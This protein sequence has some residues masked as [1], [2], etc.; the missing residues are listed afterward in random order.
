M[1]KAH[2]DRGVATERLLAN[3][4]RAHGFP[5]AER[6]V[7]TGVRTVDREVPDVGDI[8]GTPGLAWQAKALKPLT[9]AENSVPRWMVA[10]ERQR[11]AAG[12]D[13][14]VLVVRRDQRPPEQWFAFVPIADAYSVLDGLRDGRVQLDGQLEAPPWGHDRATLVVWP[15]RLYLGDLV[16]ILRGVGYGDPIVE[17][18]QPALAAPVAGPGVDA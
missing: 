12:A 1:T 7:R 14:G 17:P 8:A 3:Y 15:A 18:V 2:R 5:H 16:T 11:V 9:A 10:T 6:S 4:L 13:L